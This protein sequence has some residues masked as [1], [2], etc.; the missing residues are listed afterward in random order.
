MTFQL[1]NNRRLGQLTPEGVN[2]L[3]WLPQNYHHYSWSVPGHPAKPQA[4]SQAPDR[5]PQPRAEIGEFEL[6][7]ERAPGCF[8]T[9][10][11][12]GKR[13]ASSPDRLWVN[14]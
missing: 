8:F 12:S 2:L 3:I 7:K 5:L 4:K 6:Q 9:W 11:Q 14:R 10:L 13:E 1:K